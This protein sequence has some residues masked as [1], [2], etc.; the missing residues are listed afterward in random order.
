MAPRVGKGDM[1]NSSVTLDK[2]SEAIR[3]AETIVSNAR[4]VN[5]ISSARE[6][7]ASDTATLAR[8]TSLQAGEVQK[9]TS[10]SSEALIHTASMIAEISKLTGDVGSGVKLIKGL[11]NSVESFDTSFSD[12]REIAEN[13][14]KIAKETGLL[15][16]SATIESARVGDKGKG[17]AIVASEI[18]E[19]AKSAGS[20]AESIAAAI[21]ALSDGTLEITTNLGQ[22][23]GSMLGVVNDSHE[24]EKKI[25]NVNET[26]TDAREISEK[27]LSLAGGQIEK[28]QDVGRR[29]DQIARDI[30]SAIQ[31]SGRNIGLGT[32]LID[33]IK[34]VGDTVS[35]S[36]MNECIKM[37]QQ[38]LDN[39]K[40][41][42]KASIARASFADESATLSHEIRDEAEQVSGLSDESL[43]AME[44]ATKMMAGV[45]QMASDV[46]ANMVLINSV[47]MAIEKFGQQFV[48][49]EE[50]ATSVADIANKTNLLA[51][52][53]TIEANQAGEDGRA[54]AVVAVEVKKLASKAGNDAKQI[55][56]Q[57]S[58]LSVSASEINAEMKSLTEYMK[59]TSAQSHNSQ[60]QIVELG[61]VIREAGN[62]SDEALQLS[63]SQLEKIGMVTS[64]A[65][66]L[67]EDARKAIDGSANNMGIAEQLIAA[68][69]QISPSS[70]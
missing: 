48:Q 56:H 9:R 2:V 10:E 40:E 53:A 13:M 11:I 18:K 63:K 46:D 6:T 69:S 68:L 50:M 29:M 8:D 58:E 32:S 66:T 65:E 57:V 15:G 24:T 41:V 22:L 70:S 14:T 60:S 47:G 31:G 16:L 44:D 51:M 54:F 37:A 35:S 34:K 43:K 49:I 21:N 5:T 59:S 33:H 45:S 17:F 52:N 7:F 30:E 20:Y 39:A 36:E 12:I 62:I 55:N 1:D 27:I 26:V 28:L 23:S 61:N 3:C 19:L 42:N 67:A 4:S 25:G 64:N 38:I